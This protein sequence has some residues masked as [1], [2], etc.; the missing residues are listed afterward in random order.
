RGFGGGSRVCEGR[1]RLPQFA[2]VLS[3][4]LARLE[5]AF[6]PGLLRTFEQV[7]G[8]E[9]CALLLQIVDHR[10]FASR[11]RSLIRPRRMRAFIVPSGS[12]RRE[13]ISSWVSPLKNASLRASR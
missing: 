10:R 9:G 12:E 5:R 3:K 6:E 4:L 1:G 13:D 2:N 8:V 7:Q 11:S